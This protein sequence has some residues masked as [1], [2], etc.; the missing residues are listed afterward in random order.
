M[1]LQHVGLEAKKFTGEVRDAA[2]T[3]S[4][5]QVTAEQVCWARS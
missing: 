2:C 1:T 3:G 5:E 4:L